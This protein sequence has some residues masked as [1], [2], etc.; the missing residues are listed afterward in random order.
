[1]K[2]ETLGQSYS[3]KRS[4]RFRT[5]SHARGE[6]SRLGLR[7]L[8]LIYRAS[9]LGGANNRT[10]C[11]ASQISHRPYVQYLPATDAG[12]KRSSFDLVRSA[13]YL[14]GSTALSG[15]FCYLYEEG[16]CHALIVA[17]SGAAAG[18]EVRLSTFV[19]RVA[20]CC[21]FMA[22]N[23]PSMLAPA[24]L[25]ASFLARSLLAR[26]PGFMP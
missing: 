11:H 19:L 14:V 9:L 17:A 20:S 10:D 15:K 2:V 13:A 24:D 18:L 25:S 8:K 16:L 4:C 3:R 26:G 12:E 7:P 1:M 5:H 22:L 6:S 23:M 21:S